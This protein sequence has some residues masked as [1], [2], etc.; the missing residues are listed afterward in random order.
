[1][2]AKPTKPRR[3]RTFVPRSPA[4]SAVFVTRRQSAEML[5]C[6]IQL[7]DK[8]INAGTL[9]AFQVGRKV[10]LRKNAVLN[11]VFAHQIKRDDSAAVQQ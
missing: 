4:E 2:L 6:S 9:E 3:P 7:I 5:S 8:L 10:L 11:Y 1:M